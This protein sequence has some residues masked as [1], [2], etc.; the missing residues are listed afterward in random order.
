MGAQAVARDAAGGVGRRSTKK[1]VMER[2]AVLYALSTLA[3]TCAALAA[4]VGAVGIYRL[5][6]LAGQQKEAE[7][8]LRVFCDRIGLRDYSVVPIREV[9]A[10]VESQRRRAVEPENLENTAYQANVKAAE[11]ALKRWTAFPT[12]SRQSRR[13]L[14][15]FEV[16][17][18]VVIGA[19]LVGFNYIPLL[20]LAAWTFCALWAAT[21]G[22]VAVTVY[23][24]YAWTSRREQRD[25]RYSADA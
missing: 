24:V 11:D 21:L 9:I 7:A 1:A 18:S 16:W 19:S 12:R 6:Q 15:L 14:L 22:T 25:D 3:Q 10:Y 13:A 2:D 23:C 17:N 5:G 8:E 20:V 4:F